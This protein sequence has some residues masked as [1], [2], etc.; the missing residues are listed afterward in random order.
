MSHDKLMRRKNLPRGY[1]KKRKYESEDARPPDINKTT[2][3]C[4]FSVNYQKFGSINTSWKVWI[5]LI[6]FV[7]GGMATTTTIEPDLKVLSLK[8]PR[9]ADVQ[10]RNGSNSKLNCFIHKVKAFCFIRDNF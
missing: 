3:N 10:I 5:V 8:A 9:E 1:F 6:L 4:S 2:Q 7:S